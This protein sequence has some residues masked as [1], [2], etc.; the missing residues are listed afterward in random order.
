[1]DELFEALTLI[2][3]GKI[4]DFPVVLFGTEYWKGLT[5]WIHGT[6]LEQGKISPDDLRLFCVT[7]DP[8]EVVRHVLDRYHALN[9]RPPRP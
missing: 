1:M 5:D 4:R 2:Q 6:L 8:E 7:D 3:T 9:G